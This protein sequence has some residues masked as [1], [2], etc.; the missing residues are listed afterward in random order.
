MIS[1]IKGSSAPELQE[2]FRLRH[3]IFVEEM[4]WSALRRPD[5]LETD[6]FDTEDA[7]HM[8]LYEGKELI[9]YQRLLPT[10]KPYLLPEIYP[11]LCDGPMPSSPSIYEWTRFAV[12][13]G[14]R[15]ERGGLGLAGTRLVLSFVE[16]GLANGVDAVVVEVALGNLLK[17]T[18]S[19]FMPLPLGLIQKIGAE[20]VI[21]ILAQFDERTRTRLAGAL[22]AMEQ[23]K[24][25]RLKGFEEAAA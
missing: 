21:A 19:H 5:G 14:H 20:E 3:A 16:W 13:P 9:G 4:G 17:F 15:G 24:Q 11:H 2:A 12:L 22:E 18:Q 1:I 6:R 23:R 25:P 8:L 7:V 10:T